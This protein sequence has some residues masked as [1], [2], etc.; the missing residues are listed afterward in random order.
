MGAM[1][2]RVD[3][4]QIICTLVMSKIGFNLRIFEIESAIFN[5]YGIYILV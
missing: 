1:K 3:G 2:R 4:Q 5:I